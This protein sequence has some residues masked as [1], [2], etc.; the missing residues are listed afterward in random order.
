MRYRISVI[1]FLFLSVHS[2]AQIK[3]KKTYGASGYDE[4]RCVKQTYDGGYV[5]AGSSSSFG[6]GLNDMFLMKVDSLGNPQ[7]QR[8]FGGSGV[9]KGY[10]L[11]ITSDSGFVI[12]GYT[13]SIGA[14]GY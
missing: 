7:W 3:F 6:A 8:T 1:V 13:S 11:D 10:S 12:C 4:G 2:F 9:D 14:G 5:I